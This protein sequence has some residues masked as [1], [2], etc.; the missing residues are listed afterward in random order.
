MDITELRQQINE[1]DD[2][3]TKLFVERMK[4]SADIAEYK[5]QVGM[6][7][8][9]SKRE[10]EIVDSLSSKV[11]PVYSPYVKALYSQIFEMSRQHQSYLHMISSIEYGL[12][13]EDVSGSYAKW[14]HHGMGNS[15]FGLY[16]LPKEVIPLLFKKASFKGL[17]I[18]APYKADVL[19]YCDSLDSVA[20]KTGYVNT[21]VKEADGTLAGYNTEYTGFAEAC[22]KARISF[23]KKRVMVLGNGS[24]SASIQK[25]L[26][27]KNA[28]EVIV[29]SRTGKIN[30]RNYTQY[31]DVDI[32]V[33]ATYIGMNPDS[34][35]S[36][37]DLSVFSKLSGVIDCV[38]TPVETKLIAEARRENIPCVDG[39]SIMIEQSVASSELFGFKPE[40]GICEELYDELLSFI[41]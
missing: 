8:R 14:I 1:L 15:S 2:K 33:N 23:E 13:G 27:D 22:S 18:T 35:I 38:F 36:P 17:C 7:I 26:A 40:D 31:S 30:F 6:N 19:T 25:V 29:V 9:D 28:A 5:L 3:L 10:K 41:E 34:N 20:Q 16:S 11:D 24:F 39:L 32:L 37:V 12:V 4:I 21:I